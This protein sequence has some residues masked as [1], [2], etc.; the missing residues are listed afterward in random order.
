MEVL[1]SIVAIVL[2]L[3]ALPFMLALILRYLVSVVRGEVLASLGEWYVAMW[4]HVWELAK[5]LITGDRFDEEDDDDE[6]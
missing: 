6:A 3:F 4:I 5:E 2:L 1:M